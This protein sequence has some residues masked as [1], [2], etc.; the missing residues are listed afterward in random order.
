MTFVRSVELDKWKPA[1]LE[2]MKRGGNLNARQFFR[3]HGITDME[4]TEQ[5]YKSRAA[6]MYRSHL[7]KVMLLRLVAL[8]VACV[9]VC[10]F[11]RAWVLTSGLLD[12][13]ACVCVCVY[14]RTP[15]TV[16]FTYHLF[17]GVSRGGGLFRAHPC[18]AVYDL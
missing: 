18:G 11:H 9:C 16:P 10:F 13:S 8:I 2:V 1:E 14:V 6:H 7:K 12:G 3:A 17:V 15:L 5:K 4:K